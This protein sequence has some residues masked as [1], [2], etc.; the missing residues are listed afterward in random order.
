[1]LSS[2]IVTF[3]IEDKYTQ[4]LNVT[5]LEANVT[6]LMDPSVKAAQGE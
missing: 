6:F 2:S 1:M 3:N 4:S 5:S